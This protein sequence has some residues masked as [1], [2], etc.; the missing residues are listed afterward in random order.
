VDFAF[1][2]YA[3]QLYWQVLMRRVLAIGILSVCLSE[4]SRPGGVPSAGE[5]ETPVLHHM[6]AKSL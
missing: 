2:F 6:I 5:I 3:P 1:C 4:V